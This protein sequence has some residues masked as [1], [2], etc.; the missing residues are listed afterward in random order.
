MPI[1]FKGRSTRRDKLTGVV[2]KVSRW[3]VVICYKGQRRDWI[4]RG[5][6]DDAEGF[7]ALKRTELASGN[8]AAELRV[9]PRFSTFCVETYRPHARLHLKP[10]TWANRIY[11]LG[12]LA[13]H[14]GHLKLTEITKAEVERFQA[15]RVKQGI[16]PATVNDDVKV[17]LRVLHYAR[18]LGIPTATPKV[19][20]LAVR[21]RRKAH[22]WTAEEVGKLYAACAEKA[23][24]VLPLVVFCANTGCRRG[25]AVALTWENVDLK[26]RMISIWPTKEWQPKDNEPRYI[27]IN[28]ALLPWLEAPRRSDKWVFPSTRTERGKAQPYACWPQK[29]FDEARKHAGLKGG[30]HTLRHTFA[31]AFLATTPDLFLL[32]RI[33][34]HSHTRVTELY[35]HLLPDHLERARRA[36]SLPTALTPAALETAAKWARRAKAVKAGKASGVARGSKP[37]ADA[38]DNVVPLERPA[39]AQSSTEKAEILSAL[40]SAE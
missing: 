38:P 34:G 11:Q 17:L 8:P 5:S 21:G 1:Y 2:E 10:S 16:Q 7:E 27:P 33:L 14:L 23:P 39:E 19:E 36:V 31:T 35:S 26:R 13:E 18:D 37:A 15:A 28:D 20:D 22:A 32:A 6:K 4:V 12:T 40:L 9:V 24:N 25:E 30:P 29:R 3:L